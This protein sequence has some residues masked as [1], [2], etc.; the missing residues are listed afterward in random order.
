MKRI[1]DY[2]SS[3]FSESFKL[4][5]FAV[6]LLQDITL[7]KVLVYIR[8]SL[9]WLQ[10]HIHARVFVQIGLLENTSTSDSKELCHLSLWHKKRIEFYV[11]MW[12][13]CFKLIVFVV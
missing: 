4:T 10:N 1:K 13:V 11:A 8:N 9:Q 6:R 5:I 3:A 12:F 7:H 2:V